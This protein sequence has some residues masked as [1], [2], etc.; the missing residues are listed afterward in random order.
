MGIP[1]CRSASFGY[2]AD[3]YR[4]TCDHNPLRS[5]GLDFQPSLVNMDYIKDS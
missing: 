2:A 3:S 4:V 5:N 1:F